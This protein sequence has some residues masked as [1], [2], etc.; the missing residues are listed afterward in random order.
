MSS[1]NCSKCHNRIWDKYIGYI[2]STHEI[3]T[4]EGIMVTCG[5]CGDESK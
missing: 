4:P 2:G 3:E 5:F 1:Y